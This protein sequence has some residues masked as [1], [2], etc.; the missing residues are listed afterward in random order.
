[1]HGGEHGL[2]GLIGLVGLAGL[3]VLGL[4]GLRGRG[5]ALGLLAVL[6]AA[7]A[8]A[9]PPIEYRLSFPEPHQRWMQVD[10][11]FAAAP[12]PVQI[13]MSRTSPGRYALHE[14]AKNVYDVRVTDG[15]GRPLASTQPNPHQW[16]V[17]GHGGTVRVRYRVFGDRVDGTYLGVDSTHAHVN[18]PAALMWARGLDQRPVRVVFERPAGTNWHVATQ[19][20]PT[21]D[22]LAFTAPNLQYLMDSPAEFGSGLLRTFQAPMR[23]GD[24]GTPP[25]IRVALHHAGSDA[26]ADA[27]VDGVRRVVEQARRLFGE[28]PSFDGGTYTFLADYLP[29]AS[30]DGMEHR[31]ST[32]LSSR[33]NLAESRIDLLGTVS[34]EFIHA[35]NV[36]RI[37]P[38][39]LEPF[40]FEEANP[41]GELW[42][43]EGVTSY[44]DDLLLARA[45]LIELPALLADLTSVVS[46]VSLSPAT[47]FR[48]AE[49]MS[50]MAA[51]VDA[52]SWIDR[53]NWPNTFI[54]YYTFGAAL[55]L[56]LDFA[57][58][59]KTASRSSLDDVMRAMWRTHGKPG[60]RVA[61]VVDVP[62]EASDVRDRIA[63]VTGDAAFAADLLDRYVRGREVMD[64]PRLLARAGLVM[65]PR[66][67]E[68]ASL[69]ITAGE[70]AGGGLRITSPTRIGSAA[71]RA[72]L[73]QDD[74]VR[75]V[76]GRD[77]RTI[78]QLEKVLKARRP[79]DRVAIEFLRR[80][81][82][83][84][85]NA[86]LEPDARFDI[87]A[88]EWAG[89]T[90]TDE[91][92][93]FRASWLA[94]Q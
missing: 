12:D 54:S 23:A 79:G 90:P 17:A 75:T 71:Y 53:T 56:G 65:R 22:P 44:Y 14:F 50:R 37:R 57:I 66:F 24:T 13:R 8:S 82:D 88:T 85:A 46:Q 35:W 67:P 25:T 91:Q 20:F 10:V 38:R 84:R 61:G 6:A 16:D 27:F 26:H 15:A 18:M 76:D 62:Y 2:I 31:N 63:E 21:G 60:G 72:G 89:G 83:E 74:V 77:V 68:R 58:R 87:V 55:G 40:N 9:Q 59:E 1:M 4:T 94:G 52:A 39:S 49:D 19:L 28:Y 64:Y 51:F 41:S 80:G 47:A 36:E 86:V 73:A 92:K 30:G 69:G 34:H 70:S 45:G 93:A 5:F 3:R 32:V 33:G 42:L 48:S 43:A 11:V 7:P 29:W 81:A 78:E